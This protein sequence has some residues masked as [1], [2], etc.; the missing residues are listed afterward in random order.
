MN[1]GVFIL[2]QEPTRGQDYKNYGNIMLLFCSN[3][4][5]KV[6]TRLN[7]GSTRKEAF[8]FRVSFVS[9]AG[10]DAGCSMDVR[11]SLSEKDFRH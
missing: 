10:R 11:F 1:T 9:L 5:L 7:T 8:V 4:I 6:F 3:K 2:K